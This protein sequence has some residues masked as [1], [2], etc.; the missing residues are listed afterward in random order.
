[1]YLLL[2]FF[3]FLSAFVIGLFGSFLGNALN[4]FIACFNMFLTTIVAFFIY[5]E[6]LLSGC[7]CTFKL[8][9]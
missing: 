6:V 1:M 4:K 8:F 7:I 5:Y 3:P 2:L 9:T